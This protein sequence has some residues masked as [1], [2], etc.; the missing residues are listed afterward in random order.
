MKNE[1]EPLHECGRNN[2]HLFRVSSFL[3]LLRLFSSLPISIHLRWVNILSSTRTVDI[4]ST[5]F[6]RYTLTHAH[7]FDYECEWYFVVV[8]VAVSLCHFP[9]S[10]NSSVVFAI[11]MFVYLPILILRDHY[12]FSLVWRFCMANYFY[13]VS[14][15]RYTLFKHK[16]QFTIYYLQAL[17]CFIHLSVFRF[18]F[19]VDLIFGVSVALS[20]HLGMA[21]AI[22]EQKNLQLLSIR[23][24]I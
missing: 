9:S 22:L 6:K 14:C 17:N 16:S 10:I 8:V 15:E 23:P 7:I 24:K 3:F 19:S 18:L 4:L 1:K 11:R 13:L 20:A 5:F 12:T 2:V 21:L